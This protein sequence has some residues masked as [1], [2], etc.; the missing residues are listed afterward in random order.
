MFK[1][2]ILSLGFF[3][4]ALPLVVFADTHFIFTKMLQNG[5]LNDDVRQLQI[6][7]NANADTRIAQSGIGSL[8]NETSYFGTKTKKALIRFQNKYGI[9]G[10]GIAGPITRAKLNN[11]NS[12]SVVIPPKIVK[13]QT[14][15]V[16]FKTLDAKKPSVQQFRLFNVLPSQARPGDVL[17]VTGNNF[18][19]DVLVLHVGDAISLP[20]TE[21][22]NSTGSQNY[23]ATLPTTL[24][25]GSYELWV[26]GLKG[27]TRNTTF[28]VSVLVTHDPQPAPKVDSVLPQ[29]VTSV[30]QVITITGSHFS[31]DTV[32]NTYFGSAH[33]QS[34]DGKTIT[35]SLS[36]LS[37]QPLLK[38]MYAKKPVGLNLSVPFIISTSAGVSS[39]DHAFVVQ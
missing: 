14:G 18:G 20:I 1:K 2:I 13:D 26:T 21:S 30:S 9:S 37:N 22:L 25:E 27:S 24:S 7:L 29:T 31:N 34:A 4:A 17:A 39:S 3:T 36:G 38:T 28:P 16:S 10:T 12:L 6:V 32:I 11:L 35:F 5:S 15:T 8:N 33:V 23:S 19:N